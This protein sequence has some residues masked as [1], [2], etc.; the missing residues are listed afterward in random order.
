[1]GF[2]TCHHRIDCHL[3][4]IT[5]C[6]HATYLPKSGHKS[7]IKHFGNIHRYVLKRFTKDEKRKINIKIDEH[8]PRWVNSVDKYT[9]SGTAHLEENF[10]YKNKVQCTSDR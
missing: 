1:M 9:S 5:S 10:L 3:L 4:R 2:L 6:Q 7:C 8:T